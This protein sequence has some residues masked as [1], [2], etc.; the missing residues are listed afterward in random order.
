MGMA[1]TVVAA[2]RILVRGTLMNQT[3]DFYID[4]VIDL[5]PPDSID[6]ESGDDI[7]KCAAAAAGCVQTWLGDA[8]VSSH[9]FP[10]GERESK[11]VSRSMRHIDPA[12][13]GVHRFEVPPHRPTAAE[14]SPDAT[15]LPRQSESDIRVLV[16]AVASSGLPSDASG[17]RCPARPAGWR[18]PSRRPVGN[19]R[20]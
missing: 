19:R 9:G 17:A 6:P 18:G 14:L 16:V 8:A 10:Y 3:I 20:T 11:A 4:I 7:L 13:P 15:R 12:G 2:Q 1:S 5:H